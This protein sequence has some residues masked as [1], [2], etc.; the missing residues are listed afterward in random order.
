M[1]KFTPKK[2]VATVTSGPAS[3]KARGALSTLSMTPDLMPKAKA[4]ATSKP[5][6][7]P[8]VLAIYKYTSEAKDL[9]NT[10]RAD[11][12]LWAVRVEHN[13]WPNVES[14]AIAGHNAFLADMHAEDNDMPKNLQELRTN[15]QIIIQIGRGDASN[16]DGLPLKEFSVA[17]YIGGTLEQLRNAIHL[18]VEFFYHR[19]THPIPNVDKSPW[20]VPADIAIHIYPRM[21]IDL[22]G[23]D[24][25]I[26]RMAVTLHP[27]A[28]VLPLSLWSTNPPGSSRALFVE[29]EIVTCDKAIF[30]WDG[31]TYGFRARFDQALIPR[32]DNNLRVLPEDMRDFTV[33]ENGAR[34]LDIFGNLVLRDLVC[35]VRVTGEPLPQEGNVANLVAALKALPNLF[36]D[37][38]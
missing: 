22:A 10:F 2:R 24:T 38:F 28:L 29:I 13:A 9:V 12:P 36:F 5:A 15:D 18:L 35:C 27:A 32:I 21:G 3:S 16:V 14:A 17:Y 33:A 31:R 4:K 26:T 6:N 20:P 23:L 37:A 19:C 1:S 30:G 34:I 7:A 8:I 11:E 25:D